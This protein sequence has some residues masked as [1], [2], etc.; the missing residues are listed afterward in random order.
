ML[1][2]LVEELLQQSSTSAITSYE[3]S[4]WDLL[5]LKCTSDENHHGQVD[6]RFKGLNPRI[7]AYRLGDL[8]ILPRD[9]ILLSM[10]PH[11]P[12]ASELDRDGN[13]FNSMRQLLATRLAA[14]MLDGCGGCLAW[15]TCIDGRAKSAFQSLSCAPGAY[16]G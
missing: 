12:S 16:D 5:S 2:L 3:K 10:N 14:T 15:R 11:Q 7:A 8:R 9:D 13:R 4:I 1:Q 6:R